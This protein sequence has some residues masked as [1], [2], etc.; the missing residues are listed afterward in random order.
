VLFELGASSDALISVPQ[1][2]ASTVQQLPLWI[3]ACFG[4]GVSP[5]Y[6]LNSRGNHLPYF[7]H[8]ILRSCEL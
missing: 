7:G 3:A 2:V 1:Q 5:A 4:S 6:T 8:D